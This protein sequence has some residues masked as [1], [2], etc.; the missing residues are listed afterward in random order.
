M[1]EDYLEGGGNFKKDKRKCKKEGN[2]KIKYNLK[3][4]DNLW[5]WGTLYHL[6]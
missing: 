5:S 2:L 3:I 6:L 4:K 1:V